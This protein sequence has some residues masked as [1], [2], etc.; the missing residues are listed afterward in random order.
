MLTGAP[1]GDGASQ[2]ED[3]LLERERV[4]SALERERVAWAQAA[5]PPSAPTAGLWPAC[6]R[7]VA[8]T[9]G[10][11]GALALYMLQSYVGLLFVAAMS[12]PLYAAAAEVSAA[13]QTVHR[14][15]GDWWPAQVLKLVLVLVLVVGVVMTR[16]RARAAPGR[17]GSGYQYLEVL[18]VLG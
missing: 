13:E 14:V 2:A 16:T 10:T 9:L 17:A 5:E 4:R 1:L 12:L 15:H 3:L 6:G 18:I 7:W 8:T 11:L